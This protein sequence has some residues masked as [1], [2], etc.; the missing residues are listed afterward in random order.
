MTFYPDFL[1]EPVRQDAMELTCSRCGEAGLAPDTISTAFWRTGDLLVIDGIP[2][3]IC[4]GCGEEYIADDTAVTLD[5]MRGAGFDLEKANRLMEVPV[6][7]FAGFR[8]G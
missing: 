4:V 8:S 2:A 3:L 1:I 5:R 7:R 6:F